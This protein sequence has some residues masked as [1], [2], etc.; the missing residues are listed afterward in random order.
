MVVELWYMPAIAHGLAAE[1]FEE[2]EEHTGMQHLEGCSKMQTGEMSVTQLRAMHD[3][4][5]KA[6]RERGEL[7]AP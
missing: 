3:E 1:Q 5:L 7:S 2:E 4:I 6:L